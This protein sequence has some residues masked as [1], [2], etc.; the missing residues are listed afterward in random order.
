MGERISA[1][2]DA[3]NLAA[4]GLFI[5][6]QV[7]PISSKDIIQ[8][9]NGT[10]SPYSEQERYQI[11]N[12]HN[13]F[14]EALSDPDTVV[15]SGYG[16][17][18]SW[19]SLGMGYLSRNYDVYQNAEEIFEYF[20]SL[21]PAEKKVY[22]HAHLHAFYG[23]SRTNKLK[24][25]DSSIDI[26]KTFYER[27]DTASFDIRAPGW[28]STDDLYNLVDKVYTG[29]FE[30]IDDNG[31][32]AVF[33]SPEFFAKYAPPLGLDLEVMLP[34]GGI[35]VDELN[36]VISRY[37]EIMRGYGIDDPVWIL[38]DRGGWADMVD[39]PSRIDKE[40]LIL[41]DSSFA[42]GND[43]VNEVNDRI[44]ATDSL[45]DS[46]DIENGGCMTFDAY[47]LLPSQRDNFS[48]PQLKEYINHERCR[49]IM[50]QFLVPFFTAEMLR[51]SRRA[52]RERNTVNR[53]FKNGSKF[54]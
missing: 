40:G 16:G 21:I 46:Y 53:T 27:G 4:I 52:K 51:R 34:T 7:G 50:P 17:F 5:A 20:G 3:K 15:I 30:Y 13:R 48:I 2:E 10:E 24:V 35:N 38:F 6:G 12:A 32:E 23:D 18:K 26:A 54:S 8:T 1:V 45:F 22:R 39:D 47:Y 29:R 49:V 43:P 44:R 31:Q 36:R 25:I 19:G 11:P 9:L 14:H 41:I 42:P 33:S 37:K 28:F